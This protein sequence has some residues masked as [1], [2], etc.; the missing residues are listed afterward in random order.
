MELSFKLFLSEAE[1]QEVLDFAALLGRV[2]GEGVNY[3]TEDLTADPPSV[4]LIDD[5][6]DPVYKQL[7]SAKDKLINTYVTSN[8]DSFKKNNF[9]RIIVAMY[10]ELKK[11]YKSGKEQNSVVKVQPVVNQNNPAAASKP[12]APSASPSPK[13]TGPTPKDTERSWQINLDDEDTERS[14]QINLDGL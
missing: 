3:I 14:W 5:D 10:D 13:P 4:N 6:D 7:T 1:R 12:T 9:I 8:L 11:E 2:T